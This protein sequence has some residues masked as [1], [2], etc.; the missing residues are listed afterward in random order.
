[1]KPDVNQNL[2]AVKLQQKK[3]TNETK[4]SAGQ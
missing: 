2:E 1:M 4:Y 3:G